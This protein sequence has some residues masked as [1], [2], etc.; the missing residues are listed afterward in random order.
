MPRP[1]SEK[2]RLS[3]FRGKKAKRNLAIFTVLSETSPLA[4][5]DIH[6]NV[7]K[8]RG[9][10]GIKYAVINTRI[11][12]LEEKGYLISMGN[13]DTK[14]GGKTTLYTLSAKMKLATKLS[15][16]NIDD[17]FDRL[18]EESASAIFDLISNANGTN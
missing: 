4:I 7:G 8:L 11:K 18:D 2:V 15:S 12:A 1:K 14:Q 16:E 5:W 9:F 13:R 17:I 6:R 3:I 10:K